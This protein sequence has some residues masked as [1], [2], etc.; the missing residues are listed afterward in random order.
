MAPARL[1]ALALGLACTLGLAGTPVRAGGPPECIPG[2]LVNYAATGAIAQ[3]DVPANATELRVEM[4]GGSGGGATTDLSDLARLGAT[5][6][7]G[8]GVHVITIFQVAA[9]LSLNVIAGDLGGDAREPG[10]GAGGG[11]GSFLF[12]PGGELYLAA[13]GGGG[14][15]VTQ[16]GQDGNFSADG[17]PGGGATGGAGGADGLGGEAGGEKSGNAGGG[18]G[19]LGDGGDGAGAFSGLGGHRISSPGDALGGDGSDSGGDG[20]FG[21]GGGGAGQSGGGGGGYSGGGTGFG[22]GVDGGGAGGTFVAPGGATFVMEPGAIPGAGSVAICVSEQEQGEP[23]EVPALSPLG[24]AAL[25]ALLALGAIFALRRRGLPAAGLAL[26]MLFA[27]EAGAQLTGVGLSPV[28]ALSIANPT[29]AGFP[30]GENGTLFA[31]PAFAMQNLA[32]NAEFDTD[33]IPWIAG[34]NSSSVDWTNVDHGDCSP[35][36]SGAAQAMN[37]A[38]SSNQGRGIS[39]CITGFVPGQAYTFGADLHFPSGQTRTGSALMLAVWL[40]STDCTGFSRTTDS[41]PTVAS[42]TAGE[43]V[44]VEGTTVAGAEDGSVALVARIVKDEAG[45]ALALDFDGAFFVSAAGFLFAD[46]FDRQ[47][48]CRWS[49][50]TL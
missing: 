16:N 26:A 50:T 13:A 11:G 14:A 12:T 40:A 45:G 37:F 41:S 9:P 29:L 39:A 6:F 35:A 36:I 34:F 8:A 46:G 15:G 49:S 18:A 19:F 43:W 3:F 48:T 30:V 47:S 20:G 10:F 23:A 42:T 32:P 22:K 44:H 5:N 38:T 4:T 2:T 7:G 27:S 25:A 28:R 31:T 17:G 21:G 24:L 33:V 1:A